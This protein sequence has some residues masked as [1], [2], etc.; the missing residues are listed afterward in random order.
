MEDIHSIHTHWARDSDCE[1]PDCYRKLEND[2]WGLGKYTILTPD[3][4]YGFSYFGK[5]IREIKYREDPKT[6]KDE[7]LVAL[8]KSVFEFA[9]NMLEVPFDCCVTVPPNRHNGISEMRLLAEHLKSLGIFKHTEVLQKDGQIPV[10]KS[11]PSSERRSALNGKYFFLNDCQLG[12]NAKILVLDDVYESGST[13]QTAIGA[14]FN[15]D[16]N[17]FQPESWKISGLA[18]T[19]LRDPKVKP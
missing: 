9:V 6:S 4:G 16:P 2:I 5:L 17:Q 14:V 11:I 12:E 8:S 13:M 7:K 15:D 10:M 19:Y 3:A 18:I 1:A